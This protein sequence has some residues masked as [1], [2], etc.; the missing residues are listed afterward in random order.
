MTEAQK[1]WFAAN[2]ERIKGGR[3]DY[4]KQHYENNKE[5]YKEKS[6]KW[7]KDNTAHHNSLTAA[8]RASKSQATPKWLTKEQLKE[9]RTFYYKAKSLSTKCDCQYH[10]DHIIPLRGK[11]VCGL[12]VPWN[13]QVITARENLVKGI[14]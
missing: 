6:R 5:Y 12:H 7:R 9:I 8:H 13:L 14:D 11:E 2:K 3:K 10:V 1:I 4:I